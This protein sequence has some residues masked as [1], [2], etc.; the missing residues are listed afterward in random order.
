MAGPGW[1]G[2][3]QELAGIHLPAGA[4]GG[5]KTNHDL[6]KSHGIQ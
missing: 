3:L 5:D 4:S 2:N 6:I 1:Q